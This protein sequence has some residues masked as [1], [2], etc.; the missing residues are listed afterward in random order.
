MFNY[1]VVKVNQGGTPL[2]AGELYPRA[3]VIVVCARKDAEECQCY[4]KKYRVE[5]RRPGAINA[6]PC[7]GFFEE[8]GWRAADDTDHAFGRT[9]VSFKT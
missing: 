1:D 2:V 4:G 5:S 8:I 9:A 6:S 3:L 7:R